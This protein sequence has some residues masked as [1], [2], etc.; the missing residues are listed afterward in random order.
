MQ[1]PDVTCE[2]LDF[3]FSQYFL[4]DDRR[5]DASADSETASQTCQLSPLEITHE[6][7]AHGGKSFH[8]TAT[9]LR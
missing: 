4:L 8:K 5:H 7:T 1:S 9:A 6:R 3:T 2:A